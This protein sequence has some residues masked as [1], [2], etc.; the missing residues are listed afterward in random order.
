VEVRFTEPRR[1]RAWRDTKQHLQS[2]LVALVVV[3]VVAGVL[4]AAP[5]P[6]ASLRDKLIA[7]GVPYS[8]ALVAIAAAIYVAELWLASHRQR[9]EARAELVELDSFE[10]TF[11]LGSPKP[12]FD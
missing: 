9:K 8:L 7:Y 2:I 6:S 3:P 1:K 4:L 10:V 12:L 5:D 11:A